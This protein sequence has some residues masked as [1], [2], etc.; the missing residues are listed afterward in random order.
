MNR[1]AEERRDSKRIA[2]P[3]ESLLVTKLDAPQVGHTVV[4]RPR[5]HRRLTEAVRGPLTLVTAPAGAGKT[6][7]LTSWLDSAAR[8]SVVAWFSV[9]AG[10][11]DRRRFWAGILTALAG[12][13][14]ESL[15]SLELHPREPVDVIMPVL[16]HAL[17]ELPEPVVLVLDDFQEITHRD[18]LDDIEHLLR[19]PPEPLRVVLLSRADP[20]VGVERLRVSGRLSEIRA[21]D[22]AFTADE[23]AALLAGMGVALDA[24]HRRELAERTEG[25][26]AAIYL[27]ALA[28]RDQPDPERFVREFAGDD[29]TVADYLLIEVLAR[30]PPATRE[31]LLRTSVVDVLNGELADA[32]TGRTDGD[33]MLAELERGNALVGALDGR[34]RWYRY[35]GLFL[36]L[37]RAELHHNAP[38]DETALHRRAAAWFAAREEHA[39]AIAHAVASED[40]DLAVRIVS[41]RWVSLLARGE[42]SVFDPVLDHIPAERME[43]DPGLALAA[44]WACLMEGDPRTADALIDV[45]ERHAASVPPDRL[46]RFT[47]GLGCATLYRSRL[48]GDLKTALEKGRGLLSTSDG[49]MAAGDDADL[50]ALVLTNL[51]IVECWTGQMEDAATHLDRARR[52]A[53]GTGNAYLEVLTTAHRAVVHAMTGELR[54]AAAR[55]QEALDF[56]AER[57]WGSTLSAGVAWAV[58]GGVQEQWNQLEAARTTLN[59][60]ETILDTRRDTPARAICTLHRAR[61]MAAMGEDDLALAVLRADGGGMRSWPSDTPLRRLFTAEEALLRAALGEQEAVRRDLERAAEQAPS[62]E[63]SVALAHLLL[64][65]G[66]HDVALRWARRAWAQSGP[67][68]RST[69]I[70]ASFDEALAC[71]RLA[72][73]SGAAEALER[74]LDLAEPMG[75][76]RTFLS[77]GTTPT[78]LLRR[79]LRL[80]TA[81]PTF[82]EELLDAVEAGGRRPQPVVPDLLSEREAAILR[83]LPAMMSNQEI[84]AE[85]FVSVNT[86]KTHLRHVYRKLDV[87]NRRD[88]VRRARELALLSPSGLDPRDRSGATRTR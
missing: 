83:F 43:R 58:L 30:Q 18:V 44:S 25:W 86:V 46:D 48:D 87:V 81:H 3:P 50:H 69:R 84:A 34:R 33:R 78:A 82:V 45:A 5:L 74:T 32:L 85:L 7:L 79:Q 12:A 9:D 59:R 77:Y 28:L 73:H 36:E 17:H 4:A 75:F 38:G 41:E 27:A 20:P 65:A 11:N 51:G 8:P 21:G 42:L 70:E 49:R 37:L 15:R 31:F 88:A 55:A 71:D 19:L 10:D 66:E 14:G 64:R 54:A 16:V 60:A 62:A 40:W 53:E 35:H 57:G 63:V 72:D 2:A 47:L 26:A 56:T 13:V 24:E 29:A 80:G 52:V 39:A 22:L 1:H 67:A 23:T 76:R 6:V 61:T 68:L